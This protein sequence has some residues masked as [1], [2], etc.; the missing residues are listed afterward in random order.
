MKRRILEW[1]SQPMCITEAAFRTL[2]AKV[3]TMP[4]PL[5][6]GSA[7]PA[8]GLLEDLFGPPAV[9]EENAGAVRIIHVAGVIDRFVPE[10]WRQVGYVDVELVG[11]KLAAAMADEQVSSVVLAI[12]SPGGTVF[13]TAELAADIAEAGKTKPIVVHGANLV[14]SGG[15][16]LAA[17]A[18]A[19]LADPTA[20]IGSVGVY[21]P[22]WDF[23]GW[24]EAFGVKVDLVKT[25][26]LKGA[27]HEGTPWTPE[28]RAHEQEIVD[29]YFAAFK[30]HVLAHREI[31]AAHMT[32]GVYV[33]ARALEYGFI[34]QLGSLDDAVRL[35]A[36]LGEG[37][38][39]NAQ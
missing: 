10:L 35:A 31:D 17:G 25:G 3:A 15:Y 34:D 13:G 24:Y 5:L 39:Q 29:D 14:A 22:L 7:A 23:T 30:A 19:I 38:K 20:M 4:D 2:A 37:V 36:D 16:Y 12:N 8:A 11:E 21:V 32:G 6:A 28:Q 26:A 18:S 27:G 9:R 33:A 1:A